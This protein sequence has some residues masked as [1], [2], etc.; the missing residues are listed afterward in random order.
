MCRV[1]AA[2]QSGISLVSLGLKDLQLCFKHCQTEGCQKST[3][4]FLHLCREFIGGFCVRRNCKYGHDVRDE[5]NLTLIRKAGIES[6]T[7]SDIVKAIRRSIPKVCTEHNL[8]TM[9]CHRNV[10]MK[11]HICADYVRHKCSH[12]NGCPKGH[13]L[14]SVHNQK[15]LGNFLTHLKVSCT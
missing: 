3:C 15:L 10:C 2:R 6:F 1:H 5:H 8:S 14:T 7:D 4:I 11:F 9:G 13:N 12:G